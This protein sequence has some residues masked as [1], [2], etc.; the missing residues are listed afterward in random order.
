MDGSEIGRVRLSVENQCRLLH[1]GYTERVEFSVTVPYHVAGCSRRDCGCPVKTEARSRN[2]HRKGYLEQLADFARN[3]DTD[4]GPK[5]ERGAP[6]VKV[7]GRPPGDLAG[8][9]LADEIAIEVSKL[10]DRICTEA[11]RDLTWAAQSTRGIL[12]GL[13]GQ[14]GIIAEDHPDL[15]LDV[16]KAVLGWVRR[17]REALRINVGEAMFKGMVC[18]NCG[19]A[20]ATSYGNSGEDAVRCVGGPENEPCGTTYG[21]DEW[22]R[23]Y[24]G[25]LR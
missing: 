10:A 13:A 20:L 2:V 23:I 15:A 7:P 8:F 1:Q 25:R 14:V 12:M 22:L 19:G 3:K 17:C 6:R 5:A 16:E 21:P 18:G 24:E 11:S 9:F 4:R